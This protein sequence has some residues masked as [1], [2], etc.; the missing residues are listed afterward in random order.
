M[1]LDDARAIARSDPGGM[2]ANVL[3]LGEMVS[4]GWQ[5][6]G[7]LRLPA[8]RP[9]AIVAS[10]MGGS[11]IGGDLLRALLAASSPVPVIAVKDYRLPGFIGPGT[12][13]FVCSYSGNTEET[14]ATYEAARAAGAAMVAV[15]SGGRLA[16]RAAADGVPVARAP[17]GL[18]PRAALPYLLMPMLRTA[19]RLGVADAGEADVQETVGLLVDLAGRWGPEVATDGNLAK[20]LAA[21]L[22]GAV[23]V[24]YAG[25]PSMEPVA[26]RWKTQLNE[27]SKVFA[28]WNTFPELNHNETVG[29]EGVTAGQPPV[30]VVLLRDRDDGERNAL[31]VEVTRELAF[32]GARGVQEA[33]S[34]GRSRLARVFSLILLGDLVSVYLAALRGVDPTP[35]E[36]IVRLKERLDGA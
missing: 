21:A 31:R 25:S 14:L 1:L 8:A 24:I 3:R 2:L 18:P 36:I 17:A 34:Q 35:V 30:A 29:W 10:G 12:L 26:Q 27:N 6:A 23:P 19:A 32:G 13:V 4:A 33:W 20:R 22:H 7:D 15:T 28:A 11:G 5:A 9:T 16:E